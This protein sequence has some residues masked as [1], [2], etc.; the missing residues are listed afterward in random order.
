MAE[1]TPVPPP[2]TTT[3]DGSFLSPQL[4]DLT[5]Q[6]G[7]KAVVAILVLI[8]GWWISHWVSTLVKGRVLALQKGDETLAS[9]SAKVI[10]IALLI[11]TLV[12]VLSQFG[13][14][15]ASLV[16][17]LG[18]AGLAIGLALQGALSNVA[19]GVMLLALRPFKLG[20]AVDINGIVGT[21]KEIGLFVTN[22]NTPDNI[23]VRVPNNLIWGSPIRNFFGNDTRRLDMIF[24]ISYEDDIDKA[25]A[26]VKEII[27]ANKRALKDPAPV[28]VVGAFGDSSVDL[29]VRPWVNRTEY[30][31]LRAE[32]NKDIKQAFDKNSI[33]IPFPQRVVHMQASA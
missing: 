4:V 5:I 11:L 13:V 7:T 20:D 33:T 24:S 12:I 6:Y 30:W 27:G 32:L 28:V 16:A 19:A 17:L 21:V 10:R 8:G 1:P 25:I 3:T 31:D 14:Q 22:I 26:L 2:E 23:A 29:W 18:A 15:T 9:V